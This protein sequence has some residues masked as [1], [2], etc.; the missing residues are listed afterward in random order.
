MKKRLF[1]SFANDDSGDDQDRDNEQLDPVTE[2][3]P[4]PPLATGPYR[5]S[6]EH[7]MDH[8]ARMHILIKAQTARWH[9]AIAQHKPQESWGMWKISR[10]EVDAIL[11]SS[12]PDPRN[13]PDD[14]AEDVQKYWSAAAR[15]AQDIDQRLMQ[16]DPMR[17]LRLYRLQELFG[18]EAEH[19]DILLVCLLPEVNSRYRRLYGYLQDSM[20]H[21]QPSINLI[22]YILQPTLAGPEDIFSLISAASPLLDHDLLHWQ[23]TGVDLPLPLRSLHVDERIASYLLEQDVLDR[24]LTAVMLEPP[25]KINLEDLILPAPQIRETLNDFLRVLPD[26]L[27]LTMLWTGAGGSGR[28]SAARAFC[29]ELSLPLLSVDVPAALEGELPWPELVKLTLR[30]AQLRDAAVYWNRCEPIIAANEKTSHWKQLLSAVEE[31]KGLTILAGESSWTPAGQFRSHPFLVLEFAMPNFE[32]RKQLWQA[33]LPS[34]EQFGH[35]HAAL[36]DLLSSG[37]QFTEGQIADAV[38]TACSLARRRNPRQPRLI[39]EDLFEASRRQ[40]SDKLVA[41]AR[42]VKPLPSPNGK[43]PFADL[44]LPEPAKRQLHELYAR[45]SNH[46]ILYERLGFAERINLGKGTIALFTG[47]S[48][49]GKTMAAELLASARQTD[50]YKI[51]LAAVVS[52]YVGETEKNLNKVF[53][54]AE[55]S[56]AILFFDEADALFGKRG[57]VKDARDRWANLEVNY[58]LQRV[59][60]YDGVV[61]MAT[62]L[63]Q[64]IDGAFLRRMQL[65]VEFP[66]PDAGA[67]LQILTGLFPEGIGRPGPQVLRQVAAQF[68]LAG[69]SWKN[70]VIDSAFRALDGVDNGELPTITTPHLIIAIAREYQK[71]GKPITRGEFGEPFYQYIEK[72]IF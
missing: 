36:P 10:A 25:A 43:D 70:I 21:L 8:L 47:T 72:V 49:T 26:Q 12:Y 7:L 24:R 63:R 45:I 17:A 34:P 46:H 9:F 2:T 20:N 30:E 71:T 4:A 54:Q 55:D 1:R 51:D 40:S 67:R 48:G 59:E 19:R 13:L 38:A 3:S 22:Q 11:D 69:G 18:L 6:R 41:L 68:E 27:P 66:F 57:E 16:T 29:K 37:F 60:E 62:N 61:I 53:E 64:N 42:H 35:Y 15:K 33:Y 31:F 5:N 52:K 28:L 39:P 56:N 44:I 58:L 23:E 32:I 65:I 14:I 50:L